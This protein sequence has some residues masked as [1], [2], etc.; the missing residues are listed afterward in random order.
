[1]FVC[2]MVKV[3]TLAYFDKLQLRQVAVTCCTEDKMD[4]DITRVT[5][6]PKAGE[7]ALVFGHFGELCQ[8]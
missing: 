2:A 5:L 7:G 1:M 6:F 8:Y 3:Q 4:R